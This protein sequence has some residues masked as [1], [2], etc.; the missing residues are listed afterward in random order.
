MLEIG[1]SCV[2]CVCWVSNSCCSVLLIL[3]KEIKIC[4]TQTFVCVKFY[5]VLIEPIASFVQLYPLPLNVIVTEL[6]D[7]SGVLKVIVI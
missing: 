7:A 5:V 1:S 2:S 3:K 4:V 6:P